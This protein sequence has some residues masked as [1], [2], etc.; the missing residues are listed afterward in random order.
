MLIGN[1]TEFAQTV[2]NPTCGF[3][4]IESN[5]NVSAPSFSIQNGV[6]RFYGLLQGATGTFSGSL[7][8]NAINAVDTINLQGQAVTIASSNGSGGYTT[9]GSWY[10]FQAELALVGVGIVSTGNPI[11]CMWAARNYDNN[12]GQLYYSYLY[13]SDVGGANRH[14]VQTFTGA[15]GCFRDAPGPGYWVYQLNV[16][17][18]CGD[19][20]GGAQF[21]GNVTAG[22]HNATIMVLE[23]KR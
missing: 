20:S 12:G 9:T 4:Q 14:L 2:N 13:R 7:T 8:A 11:F 21:G 22:V 23:T 10:G 6:A 19:V 17:V 1:Y 5:G 3:F 18:G 15:S 16:V